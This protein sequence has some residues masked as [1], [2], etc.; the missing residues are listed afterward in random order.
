M[1]IEG[2]RLPVITGGVV[3]TT[4]IRNWSDG[5]SAWPSLTT[6]ARVLD[7]ALLLQARSPEILT[8]VEGLKRLV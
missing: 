3:Y 1:D 2:W 5:E 7:Q 6:R 8:R 4:L